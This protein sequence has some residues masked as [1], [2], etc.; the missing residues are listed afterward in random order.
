LGDALPAAFLSSE[1]LGMLERGSVGDPGAVTRLLGRPPL[2]V[3]AFVDSATRTQARRDAG[4]GWIVPLLRGSVAFMWLIAGVVS[5]GPKSA[6]GLQLLQQIGTPAAVAPAMLTGA[7]LLD[8]ALGVLTLLPKRIPFLWTAQIL[9]VLGYTAIISLFLPQ[10]WLEPFGPVAKNVP[11]LAAL[12]LL[13]Y[14]EK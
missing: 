14:L 1:T 3:R 7:A 2:P 11:I 9:L 13:R 6:E 5:L 12:L 4:L 8:I 10:L